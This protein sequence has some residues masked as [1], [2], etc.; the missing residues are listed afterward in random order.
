MVGA[1]I[2]YKLVQTTVF[3]L[4]WGWSVSDGIGQR[5]LLFTAGFGFYSFDGEEDSCILSLSAAME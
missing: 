3:V 2:G 4:W 5:A 1:I